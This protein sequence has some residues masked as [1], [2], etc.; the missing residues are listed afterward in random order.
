M[1]AFV[2]PDSVNRAATATVPPASWADVV[3]DDLANLRTRPTNNIR[4]GTVPPLPA[5]GIDGDYYIDSVAQ[6][7]YGP[8]TANVWP[9]GVSMVG[10]DATT[11]AAGAT[12][13]AGPTGAAGPTGDTGPDGATGPMGPAGPLGALRHYVYVRQPTGA[14]AVPVSGATFGAMTNGTSPITDTHFYP[15]FFYDAPR[16]RWVYVGQSIYTSPDLTTWTARTMPAGFFANG[17]G[18]NGSCVYD[19]HV[20]MAIDTA[21]DPSTDVITS[22]DCVTWTKYTVDAGLRNVL[23]VAGSG[24]RWL[25]AGLLAPGGVTAALRTSTTGGAAWSTLTPT[26]TGFT[27]ATW[28]ILRLF[29]GHGLFFA[30]VQGTI[31]AT[32]GTQLF[33]SPDGITWTPASVP[34]L[35]FGSN[36]YTFT[37]MA[38]NGSLFVA[39]SINNSGPSSGVWT[40]SDG[41]VWTFRALSTAMAIVISVNWD[42]TL[43]LWVVIGSNSFSGGGTVAT[44]P[45]GITWTET[46]L[47]D[48]AAGPVIGL[49]VA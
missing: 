38:W 39:G 8:K 32:N 11:G 31:G 35:V 17:N 26:F 48:G 29:Y 27:T 37:V 45:D 18:V 12:G 34:P 10:V 40:S 14:T 41:D 19:G 4:Y 36:A 46:T 25:C 13:P 22:P 3:N 15:S 43:A 30:L 2:N 6:M 44:S 23:S 9:S 49:A 42:T 5:V 7:V 47:T 1:P 20:F 28:E 21:N 16:G 33:H 24:T